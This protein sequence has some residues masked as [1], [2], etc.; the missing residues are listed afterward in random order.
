L[1]TYQHIS[2]EI[3]ERMPGGQPSQLPALME[4]AE[5]LLRN[6]GEQLYTGLEQQDLSAIYTAAH[7]LKSTMAYIGSEEINARLHELLRAIETRRDW[8]V[9][10][11]LGQQVL[12]QMEG[13]L[14]EVQSAKGDF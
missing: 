14:E 6:S 12:K 5:G 13:V 1:K 8:E 4:K 7:Q 9:V 2:L 10:M 3:F 11:Q